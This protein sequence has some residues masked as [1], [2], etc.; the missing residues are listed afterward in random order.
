MA[1]LQN[2]EFARLLGVVQTV[3]EAR[4]PDEFARVVVGQLAELVPAD[5]IA[6][7]EVDLVEG[8]TM[9][10]AEPESF[11]VPPELEHRLIEL[12]N[13]H[14][15][16]HH[17]TI[18]GDG[19][20]KRISDFWTQAEFHA[21]RIYKALYQP[22]GVEYQISLALPA[23]RP[24]VVAIVANRSERDFSERDRSVLN[25]LRPH[26]CQAWYNARDQ[27]HLRSL[28]SVASAAAAE[29]G[30]ELVVLSDPPQELTPGALVSLYRHFGPPTQTSPFPSRVERWIGAQRSRLGDLDSLELLKPLRGGSGGRRVVL[31][32]LPAQDEHP[33]AI[34]LREEAT[35]P[36]RQSL[37]SLGLTAREAQIVQCVI[38]GATNASIG[39]SLH[40]S[41]GTVKKHLDNIYAKVGVRGRGRLTAFVLDVLERPVL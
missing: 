1:R 25:L 11:V 21:S 9:Y 24:I 13:E 3:A 23:P 16:I 30:T 26:L 22:L 4:G 31:R 32:Y 19:S 29:S 17:Y 33:G 6:L 41:A 37:E 39:E 40:V 38:S 27:H 34:L 18:T 28:L 14:P 7:N 8:R 10:V 2:A 20:A 5:V 15:L 35:S 12:S 36:R